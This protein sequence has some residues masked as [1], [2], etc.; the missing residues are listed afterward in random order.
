M[1]LEQAVIWLNK[2]DAGKWGHTY[3]SS[4]EIVC[5]ICLES[6]SGHAAIEDDTKF[7][8]KKGILKFNQ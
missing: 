5:K 6:S 3:A 2:D 1:S 8:P 7:K 4:Q